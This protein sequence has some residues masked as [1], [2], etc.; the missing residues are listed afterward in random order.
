M[1]LYTIRNLCYFEDVPF[2]THLGL[3][4]IVHCKNSVFI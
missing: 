4:N 2:V 1:H 3:V